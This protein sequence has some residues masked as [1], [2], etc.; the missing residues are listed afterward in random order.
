MYG[1]ERHIRSMR[2]KTAPIILSAALLVFAACGDDDTTAAG[3]STTTTAEGS[4]SESG[5][6]GSSEGADV[7]VADPADAAKAFVE[8]LAE[9]D[10][11]TAWALLAEPSRAALGSIDDLR[12]QASELEEGWGAWASA[13]DAAYSAVPYGDEAD[14]VS[15]VVVTGTVSQEGEEAASAT[16]LPVR[17]VDGASLVSP[18][19]DD[20]TIEFTPA[21]GTELEP[22]GQVE[23][24]APA[25]ADITFVVD[26]R[27]TTSAAIQRSSKGQ[28]GML[29]VSPP[30][31]PGDHAVTAV[32]DVDGALQV[33]T[34][35]Y[36]VE[37]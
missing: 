19:E 36:T 26:D 1:D 12:D 13:D 16:A 21:P 4:G 3:D 31:E 15:V 14:G 20:S 22:R 23:V 35:T 37:G 28:I 30:L 8:A 24:T 27:G 25:G 2:L 11:E 5:G 29:R 18:F 7:S 9:G 33:A 32:I 17:T 34:A 10:V 6:S